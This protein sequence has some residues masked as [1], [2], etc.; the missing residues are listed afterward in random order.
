MLSVLLYFCIGIELEFNIKSMKRCTIW[1][2]L[3]NHIRD[4]RGCSWFAIA[5]L[6]YEWLCDSDCVC[7]CDVNITL[8]LVI[9]IN[10]LYPVWN[11]S[12]WALIQQHLL[13]FIEI[14]LDIISSIVA[15]RHQRWFK[16]LRMFIFKC[17]EK[18]TRSI[19]VAVLA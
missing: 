9:K 11:R 4:S 12:K 3:E 13:I 19:R 8:E 16:H 2:V 6:P 15:N 14:V 10:Y 17:V 18:Y 7:K 1:D 5:L